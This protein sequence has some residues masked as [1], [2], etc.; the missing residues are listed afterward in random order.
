MASEAAALGLEVNSQKMNVQVLGFK[1]DVP[2][3]ITVQGQ[4]VEVVEEFVYLSSLIHSTTQSTQDINRCSA[5]THTAMQSLDNQIWR[6]QL[7]TTT[8]LRLY[9][10]CILP[11]FLYGSECWAVSRILLAPPHSE[12]GEDHQDAP[13]HM[14][15]HHPARSEMSQ[16]HTP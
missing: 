13:H 11:L 2:S 10:T 9:N 6:S 15:K 16:S 4:E 12:T 8:K 14:A 3:T 5:I 1:E 7:V